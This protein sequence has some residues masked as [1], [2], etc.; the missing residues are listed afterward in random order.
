MNEND[1]WSGYRWGEEKKNHSTVHYKTFE[2]KWVMSD[3]K[4]KLFCSLL[5]VG[6]N[7]GTANLSKV[8]LSFMTVEITGHLLPSTF[9]TILIYIVVAVDEFSWDGGMFSC[10]LII[11]DRQFLFSFSCCFFL[12]VCFFKRAL[13]QGNITGSS[14]T[15]HFLVL[16]LSRTCSLK[17]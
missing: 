14:H 11:M 15:F 10:S 12:F 8:L 7:Q 16:T 2:W 3:T 4:W 6:T 13:M 1:S 17:C 9:S 5:S